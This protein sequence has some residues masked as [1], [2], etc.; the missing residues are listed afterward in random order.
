[1]KY[2]MRAAPNVK[3]FGYA[4]FWPPNLLLLAV[5]FNLGGRAYCIDEGAKDVEKALE[6]HP[7]QSHPLIQE[8]EAKEVGSVKNWYDTR[9]PQPDKHEGAVRPPFW[10]PKMFKPRDNKAAKSK[11][12]N[13]MQ[14]TSVVCSDC[15]ALTT[16]LE[17]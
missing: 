6:N 11:D 2:L 4:S 9:D 17:D 16:G 12:E 3:L 7:A 8:R 5:I 10:C 13:L 15:L 14:S 1:M